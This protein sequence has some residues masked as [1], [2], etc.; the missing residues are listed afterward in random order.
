MAAGG[1]TLNVF[2]YNA[3]WAKIHQSPN[4]KQRRCATCYA[5]EWISDVYV[6]FFNLDANSEFSQ[7]TGEA[8][9]GI[10]P[11]SAIGKGIVLLNAIGKGI[12]PFGTIGKG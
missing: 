7:S 12:V 2:N 5:T 9:K 1:I 6:F 11:L 4:A 10:I 3:A 8:S